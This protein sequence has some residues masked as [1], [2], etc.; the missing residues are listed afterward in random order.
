MRTSLV[1]GASSTIAQAVIAQ[2]LND[3]LNKNKAKAELNK[4]I[5]VSRQAMPQSLA[6]FLANG[7]LTWRQS[8]YQQASIQALLTEHFATLSVTHSKVQRQLGEIIICNGILHSEDFMPEKKIEAFEPSAFDQVFSANT[9]TPLR[10]LQSLMPYL[11]HY[12]APCFVTVMSARIG[13][14]SD[15][16]LGGWY[17]YRMSKAAL[18]MAVKCLAIEASRRA[19]QVKFILFHP[20]TTDTPLSKPFQRN[21]RKDKLFTPAFVATQLLSAKHHVELDGQASYLDWQHKVIPW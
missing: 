11:E 6:P 2:L 1:I 15:N 5:A 4:V 14:I 12:Q 18:N 17:S 16:Q 10:W 13:S 9:L 8:D 3:N 19:K 7:K 20:G 21:V